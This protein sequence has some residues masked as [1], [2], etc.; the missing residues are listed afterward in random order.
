VVVSKAVKLDGDTTFG[1]PPALIGRPD[2]S[3]LLREIE[4]VDYELESQE[5]RTP[6]QP[7]SIPNMSRA[8]TEAITLNNI[9]VANMLERK[10]MLESLREAKEKAPNVQITFAVDPA[11]DITSQLVAWI[12]SNLHPQALIT[13]GLQP[14]I[15]GGCIVRTPDHI[16]DFSLR[17]RFKDEQPNLIQAIKASIARR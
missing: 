5:I 3:R 7:L 13:V 9:D 10:R 2:V 14:A 8:L 12:R 15:I 11:P 1:L 17:K 16:Y 4:K 6:G